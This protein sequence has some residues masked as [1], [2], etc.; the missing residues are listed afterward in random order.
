MPFTVINGVNSVEQTARGVVLE[1]QLTR[2]ELTQTRQRE[3]LRE[4]VERTVP[5]EITFLRPDVFQFELTATPET[6]TSGSEHVDADAVTT[7]VDL[8]VTRED[9]EILL[10]T[11]ALTVRIGTDPWSFS[12]TDDT[13]RTVFKEHRPL[14]AKKNDPEVWPLGFEEAQTSEWLYSVEKTGIGF[15]IR[16]D[17]H[18]YGLGEQFTALDKR[19]QATEAWVS[20]PHSTD[21]DRSYKSVPFYLSSYGY[22]LFV[23]TDTKTEFSFGGGT[24]SAVSGEITAHSDT[25]RFLF[26]S[27]PDFEEILKT[28]T[29]VTGRPSVPPKWSFGL[30][31]SRYSYETQAEV[32]QVTRRLREEAIPCD[33]IH[34]DISWMREGCI[35][36]LE[37]DTAAFP[38]PKELI[39]TLHERGYR[40]MLIE[41]PYLTAGSEAFQT[42]LENGYLVSDSSGQ[43]H[44]L[45]RLVVSKH[46]GGIIDFT[47]P[48]AVDWW[49]Q[50][51]RDLLEMGVDGFWTDFGEYLP[52]DAILSNGTS[53]SQMRNRYPD[54]YQQTVA[55]A[56]AAHGRTPLLWSRAGWMGTQR[57]PVHWGGDSDTTFSSLAA[58][59]RG[60]LS[61]ALSGYGFWS[62]DIGGFSGT[63]SSELYIRWAQFG[64]LSSHARFH[65]TTPREPWEFGDEAL[66]IFRKFARLRYRLLPYLYTHAVITSTT[67]LPL[68]RPLVLHYTDDPATR[69]IETQYL[70]GRDLLV[71]P[72]LTA[73]SSVEVYLPDGE[74]I[75]FWSGTRYEGRQTLQLDVPLEEVPLFVR[76]GSI[77]PSREPTQTVQPGP[78]E[79]L[80][81]TARLSDGT[82]SGRY[83]NESTETMTAVTV[84]ADSAVE[85]TVDGQLP[86]ST[87]IVTGVQTTPTTVRI[88]NI[89]DDTETVLNADSWSH[90][91]DTLT[92]EIGPIPR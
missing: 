19:G 22:G 8:T 26:V 14:A 44:L 5:V 45:D 42:A 20:Q 32:E 91:G 30:W 52:D 59:L 63:P 83:Y 11:T 18:Y 75:D 35:S 71:A 77:I 2:Y 86:N 10:E 72:V 50:K 47:D 79:Q 40:L 57:L 6:P 81:L 84:S 58:T 9:G 51:H 41:E 33:G 85:L 48:A 21:N 36:D 70:L 87:V 25:L 29:A 68:M 28:Y 7:D 78:P 3:H 43:P 49:Q 37:W 46:R 54:L 15:D 66:A 12:V 60:G 92:I 23:D 82:A 24:R 16:P 13:G 4:G 61:L 56:M 39:D 88:T 38:D 1:C 55:D 34:L 73:D 74:W 65:G 90:K 69:T 67:G 31:A 64:L 62:H 80:I 76:A 17:E 53:G 27:G 89:M